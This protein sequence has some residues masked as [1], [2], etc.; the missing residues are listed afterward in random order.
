[1]N[2]VFLVYAIYKIGV[3]VKVFTLILYHYSEKEK[4]IYEPQGL[5]Y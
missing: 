5:S 3:S 1:M 4:V 2:F